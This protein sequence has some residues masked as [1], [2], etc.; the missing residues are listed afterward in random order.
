MAIATLPEMAYI[1]RKIMVQARSV[2]GCQCE[3][4]SSNWYTAKDVSKKKKKKKKKKKPHGLPYL[5]AQIVLHLQTLF[6]FNYIYC[7]NRVS[8]SLA[9]YRCINSIVSN[10]SKYLVI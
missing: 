1:V 8:V 10:S 4:A 9:Y 7:D 3:L 5:I 2:C 6:Y